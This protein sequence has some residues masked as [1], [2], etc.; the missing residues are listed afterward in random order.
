MTLRVFIP[1]Y[2]AGKYPAIIFIII[3]IM[4]LLFP[5]LPSGQKVVMYVLI[6]CPVMI[7]GDDC[8]QHLYT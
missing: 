8:I 2:R 6:H 7:V 1:T 3:I 5:S 4:L